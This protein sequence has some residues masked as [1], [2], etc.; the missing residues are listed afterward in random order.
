MPINIWVNS[1]AY[2]D[3]I[4]KEDGSLKVKPAGRPKKKKK[5]KKKRGKRKRGDENARLQREEEEP[6][7]DA[8]NDNED[9][10]VAATASTDA[11]PAR[12]RN[13]RGIS[14]VSYADAES[15]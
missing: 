2:E 8:S 11:P 6:L 4:T 12:P 9:E 3:A 10:D 14:R 7:W 13:S 1:K 15:P 5:S